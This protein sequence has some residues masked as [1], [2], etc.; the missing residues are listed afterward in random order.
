[1]E[2][3]ILDTNAL[4]YLVDSSSSFSELVK[5]FLAAQEYDYYT[6]SK[7][8]S[9]FLAV[10]TRIPKK[11]ISIENALESLEELENIIEIIYPTNESMIIFKKLLNK[12][13][14]TGI[15]I[16]DVEV[17]SIALSNHINKIY[18]YNE[19]DFEGI[20]EIRTIQN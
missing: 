16:Y 18:T 8:I 1:M 5:N 3:I 10:V 17:V 4:V 14:V 6:T 12:Y 11:A 2:K 9:E 20:E 19:K 7:N 13:Q 15:K